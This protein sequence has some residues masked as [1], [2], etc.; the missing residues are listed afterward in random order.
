MSSCVE[1]EGPWRE[2]LGTTGRLS[3]CRV[4][5]NPS[6]ALRRVKRAAGLQPN[7]PRGRITSAWMK[8][9]RARK[10]GAGESEGASAGRKKCYVVLFIDSAAEITKL[11]Q[12]RIKF[13]EF[14]P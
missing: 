6:L 7:E 3:E 4:I 13:G 11:F 14:F 2:A 10:R 8:L 12:R 9:D 1:L 5:R